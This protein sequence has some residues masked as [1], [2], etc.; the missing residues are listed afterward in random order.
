M[1]AENSLWSMVVKVERFRVGLTVMIN[2]E[3]AG[4][5]HLRCSEC[6]NTVLHSDLLLKKWMKRLYPLFRNNKE[7][8]LYC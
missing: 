7:Y 1:Q 3:C 6:G 5:H 2:L 8:P 4:Y